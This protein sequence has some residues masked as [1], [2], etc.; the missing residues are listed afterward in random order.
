MYSY[1]YIY[2]VGL[3]GCLDMLILCARCLSICILRHTHTR[4]NTHTHTH[5]LN[6]YYN[7]LVTIITIYISALADRLAELLFY[8]LTFSNQT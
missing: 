1:I 6:K 3:S 4:A 5:A 8:M 2:E 7:L